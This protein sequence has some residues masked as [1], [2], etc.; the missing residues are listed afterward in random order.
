MPRA[1]HSTLYAT[2]DFHADLFG[3]VFTEPLTA[4]IKDRLR[5]RAVQRQIEDAADAASQWL[6]RFFKNRKLAAKDIQAIL[7]G[8][9]PLADAIVLAEIANPNQFVDVISQ[10]ILA[11]LAVPKAVRAASKEAEF[12]VAAQSI[13]QVLMIVAPVLLEWQRAKFASTFEPARKI[14]LRLNQISEQMQL[15]AQHGQSVLDERYELDY[16]DYLLQRFFRVDAGTIRA[17]TQMDVDLRELFVMPRLGP[18]RGPVGRNHK[19]MNLTAAR[20]ALQVRP[21]KPLPMSV[22]E[23]ERIGLDQWLDGDFAATFDAGKVQLALDEALQQARLVVVGGP[24][25]GKSTFFE[26][27]QVQVAGADVG[28]IANDQ[29]AIPMVLRVRQLDLQALPNPTSASMIAIATASADR[30]ALMPS[31]WLDRQMQSGRVLFMLDGLDEC[32]PV[33]RD[34][35]LLPWLRD[36]IARYPDCRYL[37]SSR[38]LGDELGA[39]LDLGFVERELREFDDTQIVDYTRHWCTAVR[40]AQHEGE[41]EARREGAADGARIVADFADDEALRSLAQNPLMLSA[42]CLVNYFEGNP[43]NLRGLNTDHLESNER[44]LDPGGFIDRAALYRLCVEG[45]LHHWDARRGI[46]SA[47]SLDEKMRVCREVAIAMQADDRA[48]YTSQQVLRVFEATLQDKS[49]ARKLLEHLRYRTGLL[50]ERRPGVF[51]FAHLTF[52]EYL[53]QSMLM[54][55]PPRG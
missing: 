42:M 48:E 38:P 22:A 1:P 13:I 7:K 50:V 25:G 18:V 29:Q 44:P 28:L 19:L 21:A 30:A 5:L 54:S 27:L 15:L 23:I 33:L 3:R 8:L 47:F 51:A 55:N 40:L 31:G 46:R 4:R 41:A 11:E 16:R 37:I 14:V 9:A 36:L 32:E 20:E 2:V 10:R 53:G 34:E 17:T 12:R 35:K 49:R 45:L 39:L 6:T 24:G 52:Q 26:W 43:Q